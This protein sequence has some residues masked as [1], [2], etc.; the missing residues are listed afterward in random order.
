MGWPRRELVIKVKTATPLLVGYYT[1]EKVDPMGLRTTEI[2][3]IWR[4]WARAFVAGVLFDNNLLKGSRSQGVLLKP[5]PSDVKLIS[6]YLDKMG[7]GY[8]IGGRS[9]AS[10]FIIRVKTNGFSNISY[11]SRRS[12]TRQRI[13]LLTLNRGLEY[14]RENIHFTIEV[15]K[16]MEKDRL[17]EDTALR[18][19][20]AAIQLSGL[21]KGGR[22]GLGSLDIVS[23][24]RSDLMEGSF[25]DLV[26]RIYSSIEELVKQEES[27]HTSQLQDTTTRIPPLSLVSRRFIVIG[28]DSYALSHIH[29]VYRIRFDDMHNF[30]I[31]PNRCRVLTG[32]PVCNDRLRSNHSAW[33]LGL[34]RGRGLR[35][36]STGY[37][38]TSTSITRRASPI[39]FTYHTSAN[40]YGAGVFLSIFI[41]GDWPRQLVWFSGSGSKR[42]IQINI[43]R[44]LS[45]YSDLY[46]ELNQYLERV[47]GVKDI[48][49][50]RGSRIWP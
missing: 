8:S 6:M 25:K 12:N 44:L 48:L 35:G 39:M 43:D 3:G 22:R 28:K 5:S 9:S 49:Y 41:S 34:P 29:W 4:W 10:R 19:L 20:L 32:R 14:I 38:I 24:D 27:L 46:G 17:A 40:K 31:R 7:L 26:K 45:A 16:R 50:N 36:S 23:I 30:F 11:F 18:I 47:T 2:K 42:L 1:P 37:I 33:I 21:G 15:W 13:K